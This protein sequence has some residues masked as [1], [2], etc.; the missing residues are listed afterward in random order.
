MTIGIEK[1][2]ELF[3]FL[4]DFVSVTETS[5]FE[6]SSVMTLASSFTFN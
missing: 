3:L 1:I 4:Q 6:D 5:N 2:K